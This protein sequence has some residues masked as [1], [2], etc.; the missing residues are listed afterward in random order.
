[1][2]KEAIFDKDLAKLISY[3]TFDGHLAED[4][5]CFYL[6]SRN[7]ETLMDFEKIVKKKFKI[8]GRLENGM[9]FGESYK[10]RVFNREI[11]RFL[12]K[13]GA[14]KGNKV[15]KSFLV[16]PW[17]MENKEF[18]KSYLQAAFDCEGSI[19][20]EK[21]PKIRFGICKTEELL[22]NGFEFIE[23]LKSMLNTFNINTTNTWKTK[24]NTR[25]DGKI[26]KELY[27]KIKQDS[28]SQ[29]AKKI[30]FS[31]RFKNQRL[32]SI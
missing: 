26:T 3:L 18:S 29:F 1:M 24:A 13:S 10:Y 31:D 2:H 11:C 17:I 6:S 22:D 4:L 5:K 23:Q 7:K 16:P 9:G 21:D 25:K 27:F 28:L 32:S 19:W 12:E 14:P 15:T 30:G 8:T 20:I